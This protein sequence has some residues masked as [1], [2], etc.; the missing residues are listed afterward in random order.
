MFTKSVNELTIKRTM[1]KLGFVDIELESVVYK[2]L[3][4]FDNYLILCYFLVNLKKN[5]NL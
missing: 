2:P 4:E 3:H 5:D 1:L